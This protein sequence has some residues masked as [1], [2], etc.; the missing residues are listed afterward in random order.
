MLRYLILILFFYFNLQFPSV[1]IIT[2]YSTT[3]EPTST[4]GIEPWIYH[5]AVTIGSLSPI[6][7][8]KTDSSFRRTPYTDV[9]PCPSLHTSMGVY[10]PIIPYTVAGVC[11]VPGR[12]Y[13]VSQDVPARRPPQPTTSWLQQPCPVINF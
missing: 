12:R 2:L 10:S 1:F 7:Q 4:L 3:E 6:R 9:G 8:K 13:R 11:P 5:S